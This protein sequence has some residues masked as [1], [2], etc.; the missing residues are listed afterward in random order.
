MAA[1]Q[2]TKVKIV[3]YLMK[4]IK[5]NEEPVTRKTPIYFFKIELA[6]HLDEDG[7]SI[8]RELRA[9]KKLGVIN[10]Q[11]ENRLDGKYKLTAP[12]GVRFTGM[13][14]LNHMSAYKVN[15]EQSKKSNL[16]QTKRI[17]H[18]LYRG[19]PETYPDSEENSR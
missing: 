6:N 4:L 12:K 16:F 19:L 10:Y 1:Y 5:E 3:V 9:L 8:T 14:I 2:I 18:E 13:A 7:N 15:S 11:V 17:L